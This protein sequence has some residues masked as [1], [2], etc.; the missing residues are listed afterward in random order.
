MTREEFRNWLAK[1]D[2]K[3]LGVVYSVV[4]DCVYGNEFED[5]TPLSVIRKYVYDACPEW[6]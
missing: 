2:K 6:H 4:A 1:L 3:E 5:S